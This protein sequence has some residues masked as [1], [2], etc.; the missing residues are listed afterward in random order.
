MESNILQKIGS[1]HWPISFY[2]DTGATPKFKPFCFEKFWLSHPNFHYLAKSWW[3]QEEIEHGTC[4][5]KFQQRLENF[6]HSLKLCNKIT[7][8]NIF[9]HMREIENRLEVLQQTF[10]LGT[11]TI[12][13]MKEEEDLQEKLEE[14]KKKE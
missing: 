3:A 12:D 2:L 7:F 9:Q 6:K 8:G 1:D 10:I 4:M 5:Y 13:L 14:R 11:R